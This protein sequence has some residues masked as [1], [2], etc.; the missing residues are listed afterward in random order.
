MHGPPDAVA[1]KLVG[2]WICSTMTADPE[3]EE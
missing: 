2:L 3:L 1:E